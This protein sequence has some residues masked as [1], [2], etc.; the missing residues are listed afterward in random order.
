MFKA[1]RVGIPAGTNPIRVFL[2]LMLYYYS[3]QFHYVFPY[4]KF[5]TDVERSF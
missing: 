5:L 1:I 2:V 4:N 3:V